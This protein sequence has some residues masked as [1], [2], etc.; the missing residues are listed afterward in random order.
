MRKPLFVALTNL[1]LYA[2]LVTILKPSP[3]LPLRLW[4]SQ[5][6]TEHILSNIIVQ[7]H[8]M[9][10]RFNPTVAGPVLETIGYR[11]STKA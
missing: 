10:L 6:G 8:P 2:Y 5:T 7:A 3:A 1:Q 4:Q 9:S 11:L